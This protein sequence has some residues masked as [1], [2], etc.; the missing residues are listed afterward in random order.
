V[1]RVLFITATDT[2]VGKTVLTSL[3]LRHL[4]ES[5]VRAL[6]M[7]PF[8]SGGLADVEAIEAVQGRAVPRAW[9]NPFYFRQPVSPL[10]AA[11][12]Q[13]Q[14]IRMEEVLRAIRRM[15]RECELLLVE[16]SGGLLAP[17]GERFTLAELVVKTRGSAW[18][19]APNRLGTINHTRLTVGAL[20]GLGVPEVGVVLMEPSRADASS[21][22]NQELLEE[23]LAPV[24]VLVF[25]N[26]GRKMGIQRGLG[27]G[28][29]K[30]SERA[31]KVLAQ[32]ASPDTFCARCLARG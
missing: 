12:R 5:G 14:Q 24:P 15:R 22:T 32:I 27:G 3:L 20:R 28:T 9:V 18:V 17:L 21:G 30:V 25:P 31:K 29:K 7:K 13:G 6:A 26:L 11:R 10:A 23:L 16:G 19:V 8:C 1:S 4:R 2:G